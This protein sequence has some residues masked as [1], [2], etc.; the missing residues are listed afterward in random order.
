MEEFFNG[1][2]Q[3]MNFNDGF[4]DSK[5]S[6]NFDNLSYENEQKKSD[7][8]F[9][10]N[11]DML[12]NYSSFSFEFPGLASFDSFNIDEF[13]PRHTSKKENSRK[14]QVTLKGSKEFERAMDEAE[15]INPNVKKYRKFLTK[16]AKL[17]SGFNSRIQNRSGAPYYGYFQ[18][19][20]NEIKKTTGLSVQEFRND[21]VQQ[22]LGAVRLYELNMK[23]IKTL[24]VYDKCKQ[25]GYS[26]DAIIA[27]AW[28]GGPGGVKKFINGKGNPS[29]SHWYNGL[30]GT[31]VGRRMKEFNNY[32]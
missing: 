28:V 16:T 10:D 1:N 8:N 23:T 19:G 30:G 11:L 15:K 18:M 13:V 14:S 21:P 7:K 27:G 25:K 6:I 20:V 4:V 9:L 32:A 2:N 5:F 31:S 24:G 3:F 12:N 22:I 26:D 17:E 29:D